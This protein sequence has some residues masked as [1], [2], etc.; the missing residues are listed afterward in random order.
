MRVVIVGGGEVG[1]ALAQA[2]SGSHEVF[3]ID[4]A[5]SI[6]ARFEPLD[7]QFVLGAG[8]S[9]EAL[10]RAGTA[11]ADALVACTGLDEVNIV[12]CAMARRLGPVR[13]MCFVSREEFLGVDE[14]GLAAFGI[15]CVGGQDDAL[16]VGGKLRFRPDHAIDA[17]SR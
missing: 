5:P 6:A 12:T 1:F 10:M 3:V 7:V 9:P 11:S 14:S 15:E 8:T 17:E 16:H 2:L 13:T 4:H